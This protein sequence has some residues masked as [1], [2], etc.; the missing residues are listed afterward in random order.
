[1]SLGCL[2]STASAEKASSGNEAGPLFGGFFGTMG[3]FSPALMAGLRFPF[4]APPDT[5]PSGAD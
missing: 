4:T 5:I 2:P 3:A 1:M